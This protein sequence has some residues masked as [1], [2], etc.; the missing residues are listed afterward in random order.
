MRWKPLDNFRILSE[1]VGSRFGESPTT[2]SFYVTLGA[3]FGDLEPH[4]TFGRSSNGV[5][6]EFNRYAM[7]LNFATMQNAM[8]KVQWETIDVKKGKGPLTAVSG[9]L[10][11]VVSSNFSMVF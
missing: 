1:Y 9:N 2:N 7:G 11:H 10:L 8:V 3:P 6:S 5:S 4:F